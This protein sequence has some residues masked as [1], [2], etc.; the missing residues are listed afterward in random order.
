[1]RLNHCYKT[2]TPKLHLSN[3]MG[4]FAENINKKITVRNY[5]IIILSVLLCACRG[6]VTKEQEQAGYATPEFGS[7]QS[8][9]VADS[10]V[11][12][13]QFKTYNWKVGD[14][15]LAVQD[16]SNKDILKVYSWPGGE[17]IMS[18]V[19]L[20][21]GP[22]EFVVINGGD[23]AKTS[24]MLLYD[25]MKRRTIVYDTSGDSIFSTSIY[26][27]PTDNGMP[28]PYTYIS[29]INDSLFVMKMDMPMKSS[30][31]LA[32]LRTGNI[33]WEYVNPLIGE[34]EIYTPFDFIQCVDGSTL[35][36]AYRYINLVELYEFIPEKG[37]V[38]KSKYGLPDNQEDIEDYDDLRY[39]NLAATVINGKL[40]CLRSADGGEEGN[41][42]EVYDLA[43]R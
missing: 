1:M 20:G 9:A 38:L 14:G 25:M 13:E 12:A 10:V 27:L 41:V 18:G 15:R 28:Y 19:N 24:Q 42:V 6:H 31:Q 40:Y 8:V 39:Y 7:E 35:A 3:K 32:N 2:I 23:A 30:W 5:T 21:Q 4:I 11:I 16:M 17:R 36:V 26:D 29:Q 37:L 43:K 33:D 22:D 34:A